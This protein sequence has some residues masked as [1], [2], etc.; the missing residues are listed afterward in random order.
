V[1]ERLDVARVYSVPEAAAI[2]GV[3]VGAYYGAVARG[4]VP[5][6]RIGRRLVVSGAALQ[7]FL[8]GGDVSGKRRQ[9]GGR[10]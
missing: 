4:E 8:D 7:R 2:L 9:I 3:S 6:S 10:P 1:A 5:A